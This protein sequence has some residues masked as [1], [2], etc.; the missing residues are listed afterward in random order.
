MPEP[1]HWHLV[2]Y[3][4]SDDEVRRDVHGLLS[5]WGHRVQYSVFRVR[6]TEREVERLRFEL[7]KVIASTD[8]LML[9]RLCEGC[10]QR[11][12]V[13]GETLERWDLES[14]DCFIF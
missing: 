12:Q 11:V 13:S 3:D 6:G 10:A 2:M 8:R 5:A 1:R 7:A 4:I 9:V 14:P